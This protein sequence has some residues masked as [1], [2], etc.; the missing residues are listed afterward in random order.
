[1]ATTITE[2]QE[3][4]RVYDTNTMVY[5]L[6]S[7]N[8][9]QTGFFWYVNLYYYDIPTATW[10]KLTT[11]KL[12][13]D[14]TGYTYYNPSI[15]LENKVS[16]TLSLSITDDERA[17]NSFKA[18]TITTEEWYGDPATYQGLTAGT[19]L[20][21]YNGSQ[22]YNKYSPAFYWVMDDK[23]VGHYLNECDEYWLDST[24]KMFLYFLI[25]PA[26]RPL[27]ARFTSNLGE[28]KNL[29]LALAGSLDYMFYIP[30]GIA[31]LPITFDS[32][33]T[34][35]TVDIMSGSTQFN[36]QSVK[37]NLNPKCSLDDFTS[38]YW[39]NRHGGYE[40]LKFNKKK[41]EEYT[42]TRNTLTKELPYNYTP[43]MTSRQQTNYYTK[44]D[45]SILL[46]T[47][48][49]NDE[50]YKLIESLEFS[51]DVYMLEGTSLIP[52]N[53][54]DSKLEKK[55]KHNDGMF[56]YAVELTRSTK[57]ITGRS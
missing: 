23:A 34:Y 18:Y 56:Q 12:Y 4:S 19:Y 10:T 41:Y 39:L 36:Y 52:V 45:D 31:N 2:P 27:V 32:G 48:W 35:Y 37:I 29:S 5:T 54:L 25:Q 47:D 6:Y 33:F 9:S 1:M 28:V 50:Q 43:G 42:I 14:S 17:T 24:E 22:I 16:G 26:E 13:P 40:T 7:S 57:I 20:C 15:Y 8:Y 44:I 49:L 11:T 3:Y 55:T 46:N 21:A 38:L 53:I 30:A 51:T